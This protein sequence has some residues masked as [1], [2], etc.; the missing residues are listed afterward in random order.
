MLALLVALSFTA[1]FS[2]NYFH[3]GT[4]IGKYFSHQQELERVNEEKVIAYSD[5]VLYGDEKVKVS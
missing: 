3:E 2:M 5:M 1:V 4:A